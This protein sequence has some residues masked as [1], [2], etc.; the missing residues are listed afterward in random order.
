MTS[1]DAAAASAAAR[2]S[3]WFPISLV[4]RA[5]SN[6]ESAS[7]SCPSGRA[8]GSPFKSSLS[9]RRKVNGARSNSRRNGPFSGRFCTSRFVETASRNC[10]IAPSA[11][12]SR[13]SALPSAR[14]LAELADV[15]SMFL[16][17]STRFA[18]PWTHATPTRPPSATTSAT[19]E[20]ETAVRFRRAHRRAR[21]PSGS[22]QAET[23]SS[24]IQ[25]SMSSARSLG[26]AYRVSGSSAI[27]LTQTASSAR[28]M[29]GSTWRGR[30]N[31]PRRTATI[32]SKT[33]PS[34]GGRPVKRQYSVA[35][36]L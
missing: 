24:A 27:A 15:S 17:E 30:A 28:S 23:A 16:A 20:D 31:S 26:V 12:P 7:W 19:A 8:S 32:T 29:L 14:A 3:S 4:R 6:C 21:R 22:R 11:S 36:K 34:N 10:S 1:N 33:S 5:S 35:P 2:A 25:R 18:R 9:V 13:A